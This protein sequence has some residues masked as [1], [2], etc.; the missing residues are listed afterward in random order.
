MALNGSAVTYPVVVPFTVA[1]TAGTPQ[2]HDAVAG[3]IVIE[4]GLS[5]SLPVAIAAD[6]FD[7]PDETLRLIMGTPENA[8]AGVR[9]AHVIT[10]SEQNQPPRVEIGVEQQGRPSTTIASGAGLLAVVAELRDDPAQDHSFDWSGSDAGAF[11]PATA[12][13]PS[14]LLDPVA[15][16]AGLYGLRV[17]VMDDG[18]PPLGVNTRSLLR[19]EDEQLILRF[20]EDVDGDGVNDAEEGPDD[21]DGDRIPDYLDNLGS[22]NQLR[23]GDDGRILEAETGRRLRLGATAFAEASTFAGLEESSF[24]TDAAYGFPSS[25]VDFEVL[26]VEQGGSARVVVPLAVP[27]APGSVYKT[28][29]NGDW[30]TFIV[31]GG[32][33]LESAP[34]TDGACPPAGAAAY[35]PGLAAGALCVQLV[36]TD[37]GPNDLDGTV[38]AVIRST[39]GLATPVSAELAQLSRRRVRLVGDGE[40]V[41]ARYRLHSASGDVELRSVTIEARGTGDETQIDAVSLIVDRN[42]DGVFDDGDTELADGLLGADNGTLTLTLA[43]PLRVAGGDTDLM[44]VYRFGPPID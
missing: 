41:V 9:T 13:D 32:D 8:V 38:D 25:V 22:I 33:E 34:G 31:G 24:G 1:G 23:I 2:D 20:D 19:V 10:I 21:S 26:R 39:G 30:Q 15:L 35:R 12:N 36:L 7:E 5:A 11:D 42:R 18:I 27:T 29:V 6:V 37:G 44:V 17:D 3:E 16:T 14:Y 43:E 28:F 4:S 40:A